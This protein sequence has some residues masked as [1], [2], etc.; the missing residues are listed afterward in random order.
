MNIIDITRPILEGIQV[1]PGDTKFELEWTTRLEE[2]ASV[3]LGSVRLSLHT[4]T[5]ADAPFHVQAGGARIGGLDPGAFLGPARVADVRGQTTLSAD[6]I[7]SVL[8][9]APAERL[10]LRTGAWEDVSDFPTGFLTLEPDAVAVLRSAGIRL[11]G[12]DAP[13]VDRFESKDLPVHHA[14]FNAGISILENL[15]LTGVRPDDYELV[16]LP[17]KLLEGDGSPVRAVL[18]Q[19]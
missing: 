17:L 4:G 13:S 7:S 2:G 1:W 9:D 19:S 6:V 16:A 18:R 10:L 5:H 8:G 12:T 15:D 11:F 3:N 14:L